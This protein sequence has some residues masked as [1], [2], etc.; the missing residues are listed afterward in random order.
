MNRALSCCKWN[1]CNAPKRL[2]SVLIVKRARFQHNRTTTKLSCIRINSQLQALAVNVVRKG[3]DPRWKR[4]VLRDQ[5]PLKTEHD[6]SIISSKQTSNRQ[7]PCH[8][9]LFLPSNHLQMK[10][11]NRVLANAERL[12]DYTIDHDGIKQS[13]S[14]YLWIEIHVFFFFLKKEKRNYYYCYY[15]H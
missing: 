11:K 15:Y 13:N 4:C 12:T 3:F 7:I 10:N 8:P 14:F 5:I 1:S 6:V 2:L 9:A